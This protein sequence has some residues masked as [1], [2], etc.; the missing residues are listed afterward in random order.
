M[1]SRALKI[2]MTRAINGKTRER[3]A[4]DDA[5]YVLL[6]PGEIARSGSEY[7]MPI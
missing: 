2:A 1:H 7:H 6:K 3:I 4:A 5:M